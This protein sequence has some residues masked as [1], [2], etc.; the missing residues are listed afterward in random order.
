MSCLTNLRGFLPTSMLDWPGKICA[1]LFTGGCN[2]RCPYCHNPELV[3]AGVEE[4][5]LAWDDFQTY[6]RQRVGWIDGVSITGGEPTLHSD[7]HQLCER[8]RDLGMM[9]KLDTNGSR[10]HMLKGLL[11]KNLLDF[12]AMDVK[13][14]PGKYER[15]AGWPIEERIIGES[16]QTI[17]GS[18]LEHEFR[19][20]VVPGLVNLDDLEWIARRVAGSQRLVLQQ[21]N[22]GKTLDPAYSDMKGYAEEMLLQWANTLSRWVP[23]TARGLV[24]VS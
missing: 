18:G 11:E 2:F 23:T 20:T 5:I 21:F 4:D 9:V 12:L 15:V 6:L 16:I 17:L 13:T 14:S 8:I 22:P 1:V 24:G 10:P 7:L 3:A 19:C